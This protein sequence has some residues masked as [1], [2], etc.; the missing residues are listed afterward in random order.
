MEELGAVALGDTD[1]EAGTDRVLRLFSGGQHN[2]AILASGAVRC[3][4]NNES[5]ELGYGD[6]NDIGNIGG[7]GRTPAETY[8]QRGRYDVCISGPPSITTSCAN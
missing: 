6:Y 8:E 5:G 2:C 1:D 4:G 3:W 7:D